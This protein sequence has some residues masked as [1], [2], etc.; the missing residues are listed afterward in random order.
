MDAQTVKKVP[1]EGDLGGLGIANCYLSMLYILY[2]TFFFHKFKQILII[3]KNKLLSLPRKN[4][5]E[6]LP[7]GLL[8]MPC[9]PHIGKYNH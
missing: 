7:A 4:T 9:L 1:P 2:F 5:K 6:K 8:F 3:L